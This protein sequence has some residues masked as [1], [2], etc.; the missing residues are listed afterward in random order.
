MR[1]AIARAFVV[2]QSLLAINQKS[3]LE[4]A[5]GNTPGPEGSIHKYASAR[6]R[7]KLAALAMEVLGPAGT[8]FDPGASQKE[9]VRH[10][11]DE[12]GDAQDRRWIG[13][14][15]AEYDSGK[16]RYSA[17]LPCPDKGVPFNRI[18]SN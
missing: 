2:Q 17:G 6:D 15:A 8:A 13:R 4:L 14:N 18:A 11:L 10:V 3:M 1:T 9:G 16:K 12:L 5:A 7:R